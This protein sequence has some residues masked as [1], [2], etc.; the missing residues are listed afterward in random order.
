[1]F[2]L[3]ASFSGRT[4]KSLPLMYG[5]AVHTV[6]YCKASFFFLVIYGHIIKYIKFCLSLAF[7]LSLNHLQNVNPF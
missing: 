7:M 1:M 6:A 3:H 4:K 2:R 5:M